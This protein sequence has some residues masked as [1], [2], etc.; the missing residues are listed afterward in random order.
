MFE[1][2][3]VGKGFGEVDKG[4]QAV[5]VTSFRDL[6]GNDALQ[7]RE[8]Q[9]GLHRYFEETGANVPA[10]LRALLSGSTMPNI[11]VTWSGK[12]S[13]NAPIAPI[14]LNLFDVGVIQVARDDHFVLWVLRRQIV[15]SLH[16]LDRILLLLLPTTTALRY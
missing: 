16:C 6:A 14:R 1:A 12:I 3:P 11:L 2:V 13:P 15:R 8:L 10:K 7:V 9:E 5:A 4:L